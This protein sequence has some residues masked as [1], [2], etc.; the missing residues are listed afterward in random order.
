ML[1]VFNLEVSADPLKLHDYFFLTGTARKKKNVEPFFTEPTTDLT[2]Q[3][4]HT[5]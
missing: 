4:G 3:P 1:S 5:V 2:L